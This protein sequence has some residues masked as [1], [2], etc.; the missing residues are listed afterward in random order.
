MIRQFLKY[1]IKMVLITYRYNTI[2][3]GCYEV[4]L[5]CLDTSETP[6]FNQY[7]SA[8]RNTEDMTG[9]KPIAV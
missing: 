4:N 9:G 6:T 7:D 2:K 5:R 1:T 3:R 8:K